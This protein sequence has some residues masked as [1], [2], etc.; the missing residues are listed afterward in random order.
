MPVSFTFQYGEIKSTWQYAQSV[1]DKDLHSSMERLKVG[2]RNV[3]YA[4]M[5]IFT[6]QYGEIKSQPRSVGILYYYRFT[7]QYGEIKSIARARKEAAGA[8]IY[9]P[10]WRD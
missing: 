1:V 8:R 7:F 4:K 3:H 6:F 2:L 5:T 10:V 9:I